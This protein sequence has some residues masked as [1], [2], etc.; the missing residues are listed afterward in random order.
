M[1]IKTYRIYTKSLAYELRKLG[2][3]FMG[4]D[5]N[6]NFP[7]Y[8]VYLFEDTPALHAALVQLTHK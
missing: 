8:L 2:F 5:I 7:Q 6:K 3:R 4:T 1:N